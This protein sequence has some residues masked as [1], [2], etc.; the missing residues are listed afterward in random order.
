MHADPYLPLLI[1]ID[2]DVSA[3]THQILE[4]TGLGITVIQFASTA[5]VKSW[6]TMNIGTRHLFKDIFDLTLSRTDFLKK[7]DSSTKIRFLCNQVLHERD[8]SHTP[9]DNEEAGGQILSHIRGLDIHAPVLI[10]TTRSNITATK[11]VEQYDMAGS[12]GGNYS[13]FHSYVVALGKGTT[14][15][16]KWMKY[17]A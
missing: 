16:G 11:Y 17:D 5:T 6:I 12:L 2:S 4:C 7:H 3:I 9:A 8:S 14:D 15:E 13:I 1:W 10:Y